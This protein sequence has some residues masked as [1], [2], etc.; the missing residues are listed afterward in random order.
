[1]TPVATTEPTSEPSTSEPTTSEPTTSEPTTSEPTSAEPTSAEP[2][3]APSYTSFG[4]GSSGAVTVSPTSQP[5]DS[6]SPGPV[7]I[8]SPSPEPTESP[9][10]LGG[11]VIIA[12]ISDDTTESPDTA[13]DGL[14]GIGSGSSSVSGIEEDVKT[15]AAVLGVA[16]MA[17]VFMVLC[18]YA[19]KAFVKGS[20]N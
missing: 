8:D 13:S 3:A 18:A 9:A 5:T 2:T 7:A 15:A 10:D 11:V 14:G 16:A 4:S 19:F 17:T 6:P 1:M 20:I 12:G